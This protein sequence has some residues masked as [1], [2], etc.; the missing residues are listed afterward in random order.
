[1]PYLRAGENHIRIVFTPPVI[2]HK[3][4]YEKA[5]YHLPAPNDNHKIA[6]APYTRKPQYQ[7]GWDWALRMNTIGLNKSVTV[8]AY[9]VNAPIGRNV[10]VVSLTET[11]ALLKLEW[12]FR[13]ELNGIISWKSERF[14]DLHFTVK[15]NTMTAEVEL[16][17]PQVWWP[18]GHG[19]P[20]L[21]DDHWKLEAVSGKL[22]AEESLQFGVRTSE[23][24]QEADE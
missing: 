13:Q 5:S 4:R 18:R 22:I 12:Q 8:K 11:S 6:V 1:K 9:S 21:Y 3:E 23:L 17:N 2:Y 24:V 16:T 10:Q 14:G 19:E 7:F 20:Y 15:G